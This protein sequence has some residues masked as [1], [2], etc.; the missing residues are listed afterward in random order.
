MYLETKN[1][2]INL[3]CNPKKNKKKQLFALPYDDPFDKLAC[4]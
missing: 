2:E 4:S 1:T 3:A